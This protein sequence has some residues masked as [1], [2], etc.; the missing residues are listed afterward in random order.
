M[1]KKPEQRR[2]MFTMK[3]V[4]CE[5]IGKAHLCRDCYHPL[6]CTGCF[7]TGYVQ[8]LERRKSNLERK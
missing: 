6:K 1:K 5:G 8:R 3:C 2:K 4:E 7:G